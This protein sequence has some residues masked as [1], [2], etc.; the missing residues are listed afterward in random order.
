ME[1]SVIGF[2]SVAFEGADGS[3]VEVSFLGQDLALGWN[4][5]PALAAAGVKANLFNLLYRNRVSHTS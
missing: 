4:L 3:D 5:P 1:V 2:S